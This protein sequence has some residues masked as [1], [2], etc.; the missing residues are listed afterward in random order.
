MS[1]KGV[2]LGVL[3]LVCDLVCFGGLM[4]VDLVIWALGY[5]S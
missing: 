3:G 1:V 5:D 2:G 4:G